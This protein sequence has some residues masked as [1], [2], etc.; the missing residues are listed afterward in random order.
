MKTNVQLK[1]K[2]LNEGNA[3]ARRYNTR[4]ARRN[5]NYVLDIDKLKTAL[6][7]PEFLKLQL[8]PTWENSNKPTLRRLTKTF[9]D[10]KPFASE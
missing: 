3:F 7:D 4:S 1:N 2:V 5:D 10:F 6:N 8:D 9:S